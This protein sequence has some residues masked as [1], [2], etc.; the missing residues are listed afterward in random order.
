MSQHDFQAR[1][2]RIDIQPQA[3]APVASGPSTPMRSEPG[4]MDVARG[5]MLGAVASLGASMVE[6]HLWLEGDA[7]AYLDGAGSLVGI[8]AI[9]VIAWVLTQGVR[10]RGFLGQG[11]L[12]AGVIG[13]MSAEL[14]LPE[15]APGL[16]AALFNHSFV[17]LVQAGHV[18]SIF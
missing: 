12:I 6:F 7:M 15:V 16:A 9:I 14:W 13:E 1:L 3:V 2:A 11:G 5:L 10:V 17:S 8:G 18:F 4:P